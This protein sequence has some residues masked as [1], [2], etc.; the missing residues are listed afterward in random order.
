MNLPTQTELLLP[1]LDV[2]AENGPMRA[3]DACDAVA[4]RIGLPAEA[5][6]A[7]VRVGPREE[8]VKVFDRKVRW[9]RQNAVLA[10]LVAPAG[11]G[12]W[13][14]TQTGAKTDRMAKPSVVVTVYQSP[15]GALLWAE[16]KSAVQYV[17]DGAVTCVLTS[18]PYPLVKPRVYDED[19]SDWRPEHYLTTLLD[20]IELFR[21]KLAPDGC[22]VLNLGPTFMP[23]AGVRNAYQH[24]LLTALVDNLG[25]NL[26]DEHYW[27]NPTKPRSSD[28]VTKKRTHCVNGIEPVYLLSPNGRT[29]CCNLRVLNPYTSR[30]RR[31]IGSGGEI[32]RS[33]SPSQIQTPGIRHRRDNGGCIPGNLHVMPPD[34]DLA[35]RRYCA[36][37]GVEQHPAMMPQK[38]AEFFI[39][40]TTEPGDLVWDPF[41]GS[42]K[43]AAAA[44]RLDRRFLISE[45]YLDNL[46]GAMCRLPAVGYLAGSPERDLLAV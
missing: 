7:T 28:Y 5:R 30:H 2:L 13:S 11:W 32:V 41:G 35:Y 46:R 23:G 14:L 18:P 42:A 22:F 20:H 38:L 19:I 17:E 27:F 8:E 15:D 1:L 29:K 12:V 33:A 10:D 6:A 36:Q 25:W 16:A 3:R 45:R 24:R 31:L 40:F 9:T 43:T 39:Q 44:L 26:I 21:P 34:R 37:V 4:E